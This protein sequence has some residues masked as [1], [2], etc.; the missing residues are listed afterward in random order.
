MKGPAT[1]P[2]LLVAVLFSEA[3]SGGSAYMCAE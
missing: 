3:R 2:M 1:E